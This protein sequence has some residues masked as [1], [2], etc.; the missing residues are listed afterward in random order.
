VST[1]SRPD[2][3]RILEAIRAEARAR[4]A[5]G[6]VGRYADAA[7]A[8]A[9]Q[10]V[11]PGLPQPDLRDVR[12]F[13]ALPLDIFVD[14]AYRQVLGR[15]GDAA[16]SAYYQRMLLHGRI[17]RVEVLGRLLFSPEGRARGTRVPGIAPAFMFAMLYRVPVAGPLAAL[18]ARLLR[19][20]AHWQD[21]SQLEAT[22]LASGGWMK[23]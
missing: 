14:E 16:G 15:P 13:L 21:R 12:D 7:P 6:V 11:H 10:V 5:K 9:V 17:T 19:L 2:I 20:P 8:A 4:G 3:D 23:R 1:P 18:A 22:A